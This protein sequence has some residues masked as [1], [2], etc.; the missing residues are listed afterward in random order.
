MENK[1]KALFISSMNYGLYLGIVMIVL[2]LLLFFF[3]IKPIGFK[4][5]LI[6]VVSLAI[7]IVGIVY[8]TKKIRTNV[9][10]GEMTFAQG[11]LIGVMVTFVAVLIS[12]LY[13][14]IQNTIID[15]DYM[16]NFLEA[17]K[18]W[19]YEFMSS[20]GVSEDQ[21]EK[22]IEGMEDKIAEMNPLKTMLTSI[23][24]GT[25]LGFIIS[26]ITSAILKKK[27]DNPFTE[28]QIIE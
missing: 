11:L 27:N 18:E 14:Y 3:D 16:K 1:S 26:L 4:S 23:I 5:L 25:I 24:S 28:S 22:A 6:S 7:T 19:M 10:G 21:I 20:K 15:P 9:L 2:A 17:Q 8:S 13:S 12:S